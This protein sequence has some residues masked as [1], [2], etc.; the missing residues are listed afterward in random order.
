MFSTHWI[1]YFIWICEFTLSLILEIIV[2]TWACIWAATSIDVASVCTILFNW[3]W[4]CPGSIGN[5]HTYYWMSL[6]PQLWLT[7]C[8]RH[9]PSCHCIYNNNFHIFGKLTL[10]TN[11][12]QRQH[13]WDVSCELFYIGWIFSG[14]RI[15]RFLVLYICFADRCLSFCTF[16]FGHCA[17][18]S[19]SVY[20]FWL[21]L[22]YTQPFLTL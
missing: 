7:W 6:R 1:F 13:I 5:S 9:I 16:S 14:V 10:I 2:T 12:H 15:T 19:S 4:I 8:H 18:C 22:W 20:G 21:S 17:V 3:I 11:N